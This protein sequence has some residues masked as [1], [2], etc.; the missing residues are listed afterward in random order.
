[1]T[2][3]FSTL[4]GHNDV[5]PPTGQTALGFGSGKPPPP[6]PP[7]QAPAAAQIT[8]QLGDE[9]PT[10]RK[11]GAMNEPFYLLREL[12]GKLKSLF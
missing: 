8:A 6:T 9:G 2:E 12:P 1:M 11:P 7:N 4:F 3:I 5:Q 10:P